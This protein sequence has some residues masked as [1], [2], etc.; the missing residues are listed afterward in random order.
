M[1]NYITELLDELKEY[2]TPN[3][4]LQKLKTWSTSTMTEFAQHVSRFTYS[5]ENVDSFLV[6]YVLDKK[7]SRFDIAASKDGFYWLNVG[8]TNASIT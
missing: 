2:Q 7:G 1:K 5:V 4:V 8:V 6:Y 3:K